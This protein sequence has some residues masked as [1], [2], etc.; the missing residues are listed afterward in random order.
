MKHLP[1]ITP[2]VS[3]EALM[4]PFLRGTTE[5]SAPFTLV[6]MCKTLKMG[7]MLSVESVYMLLS[8]CCLNNFKNLY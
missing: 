3:K 7:V 1:I 5:N 8:L 4:T 2:Q 6:R